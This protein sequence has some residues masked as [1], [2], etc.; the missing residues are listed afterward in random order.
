MESSNVIQMG[1]WSYQLLG[2]AGTESAVIMFV[3]ASAE[4]VRALQKIADGGHWLVGNVSDLTGAQAVIDKVRPRLVVCE[5][6]I[7]GHGS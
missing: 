7:E 3:S 2:G 4:D 5:T 1:E 6:E